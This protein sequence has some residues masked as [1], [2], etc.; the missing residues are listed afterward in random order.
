MMKESTKI[1]WEDNQRIQTRLSRHKS[2]KNT[3]Y[4]SLFLGYGVFY[5]NRKSYSSLIPALLQS[6]YLGESELGFISSCFAFS[7]GLSKFGSGILSDK[8]QPRELFVI[9]LIATGICNIFFTFIDGVMFLSC[10]WLVNG[11]VQGLA[12]PQCAK[13]LKVW[14]EPH[15]VNATR[16]ILYTIPDLLVAQHQ[17]E[18]GANFIRGHGRRIVDVITK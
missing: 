13:L 14:F 12:W 10:V 2:L 4:L 18:I 8:L 17:I 11:L 6:R 16:C 7:Y 15:E 5:Y 9:G 3:L 1:K